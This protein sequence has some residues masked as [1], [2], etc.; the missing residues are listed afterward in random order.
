MHPRSITTDV[1]TSDATEWIPAASSSVGHG[2][3]AMRGQFTQRSK[4][5]DAD[6]A[7]YSRDRGR[8]GCENF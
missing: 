2:V 8:G 5:F 3:T 4:L 1:P 7:G 6:I